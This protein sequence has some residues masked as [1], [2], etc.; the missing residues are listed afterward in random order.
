MT[1]ELQ[2]LSFAAG[3]VFTLG[4]PINEKDL[5]AGRREQIENIID[6]VS[7]RGYHAILYGERGVGKTSLSNMLSAFLGRRQTA[8]ISRINCD[9][10]DTFSSSW[11]KALK[12]IDSSTHRRPV[13]LTSLP[14][15]PALG[16]DDDNITPDS[17][18]R[19][20]QEL[21]RST[22]LIVIFDEFDR[23]QHAGAT[24]LMADTIKSLSDY[25]VPATILIIGVADS[26]DGLIKEHQS[27]ERALIQV[28]MPRMSDD[29]IRDIIRN[30]LTRLTMAIDDAACEE[31]VRF[32]QGVP[33]IAH[34]LAL[35]SCRS[36]LASGSKFVSGESVE[37][38]MNR[39]LDQ[40][41]QSIK[42][43]YHEATKGRQT[44]NLYKE[45]LLACALAEVDDLRYFTP[46]AVREPL[47]LIANRNF[48]IANFA[49]HLK[50]LSE[51][52]RGRILQR[53][54]ETYGTRYRIMNPIL[55]PYIVMRSLKDNI[56]PKA[57]LDRMTTS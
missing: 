11:M 43:S 8:L 29:E 48:E 37:R 1:P 30:G 38:G 21:S 2:A 46:A 23:V 56:A 49:R 40:W 6:A 50:D 19:A 52:A 9:T 54:G 53:V 51:A 7:Q 57:V 3:S 18:R 5:F 16:L 22:P 33:Y 27:I 42:A 47:S 26:V 55:R 17:A 34:L 13:G 25:S 24:V 35:H 4:A 32:S 14:P 44:G 20:L 41:Q 12:E 31:L 10:S 45:V 28:H 39:S 36:A 15:S